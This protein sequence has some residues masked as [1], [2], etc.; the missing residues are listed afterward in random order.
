LKRI[1]SNQVG[2]TT[3]LFGVFGDPVAHSLSPAMHNRAFSF[4]GYKGVYLPFHVEEI[5]PAVMA[6][7]TLGLRG[8][9]VTLPHKVA[10][11]EYL[12]RLD[13]QAE[14]IG[15]V[16]TIVN[17][18]GILS[19]YNT[20][21]FGAV[22]ALAQHTDIRDKDVAIIGAGGAARAIGWGIVDAGGKVIVVNR[23]VEK[24]EQL[25][26]DL[27]AGFVPLDGANELA[28]DIVVNT[29]P[30]GMHPHTGI[31]P[32][33][34]G[35]FRRGMLVMDIVYTPLK[36]E[37]LKQAQAAGSRIVDGLTMFVLQG[38]RQFELWTGLE[39]PV[40]A[41]REAVLEQLNNTGDH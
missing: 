33:P 19:G 14:R 17:A 18:D 6:V 30:L 1:S 29:T 13:P 7:R 36:T 41:M 39:A 21:C 23:S 38:A 10:V 3:K 40:A 28:A 34:A 24:G 11:M 26:G 31:M 12:D 2:N 27:S 4:A 5:E 15:A 16:N 8:I 9:S 22:G 37:F 20:D 35:I 25:A 32:V